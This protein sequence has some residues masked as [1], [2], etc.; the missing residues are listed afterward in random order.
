MVRRI[1]FLFLTMVTGFSIWGCSGDEIS[2]TTPTGN[3]VT[4][5]TN[6][7]VLRSDLNILPPDGSVTVDT[8]DDNQ[9]ILTGTVPTI[10]PGTALMM[11]SGPQQFIRRVVSVTTAD[12]K[13]VIQTTPGSL[14]DVFETANISQ[15]EVVGPE[16]LRQATPELDGVSFGEPVQSRTIEGG[17]TLPVNFSNSPLTDRFG[18]VMA[19]V[20]GQLNLTIGFQQ[21]L[22]FNASKFLDPPKTLERLRLVPFVNATG[23]LDID[24]KASG[25]FEQ[26]VKVASLGRIPLASLGPCTVTAGVD[27]LAYANGQFSVT[28]TTTLDGNAYAEFGLQATD[29]QFSLVNPSPEVSFTV[30]PP[31]ARGSADFSCGLARPSISIGVLGLGDVFVKADAFRAAVHGEFT[32]SPQPGYRIG[33][34]A[35]FSVLAGAVVRV[36]PYGFPPFQIPEYTIFNQTLQVVDFRLQLGD[37]V[38]IANEPV[39]PELLPIRLLL[40]GNEPRPGEGRF[41]GAL[42][43]L[44]TG[45]PIVP[46]VPIYFPVDW[47]S[48]NTNVLEVLAPNGGFTVVRAKRPGTAQLVGTYPDGKKL[49][50]DLTVPNAPIT[51]LRV[52]PPGASITTRASLQGR[53]IATYADGV[54]VDVTDFVDWATS[55]TGL[56]VVTPR[57]FF[58]PGQ[59]KVQARGGLLQSAAEGT[60]QLTANFQGLD[61]GVPITL[62]QPQVLQLDILNR[63][64]RI[65]PGDFRQLQ[66]V[67]F[68]ADGTSRLVSRQVEW[69]SDDV[70]VVNV[71]DTG[72]I[73]AGDS[74]QTRIRARLGGLERSFPISV[75]QPFIKSL[76]FDQDSV[77][78]AAGATQT[79]KIKAT[80]NDGDVQDVTQLAKIKILLPE[81]ANFDKGT[82]TGKQ[83]GASLVYATFGGRSAFLLVTVLPAQAKN[84]FVGNNGGTLNLSTVTV[85]GDGSLQV[86]NNTAAGGR[87]TDLLHFGDFVVASLSGP[88]FNRV[89]VF[90]FDA[91]AQDVNHVNP[92]F[93]FPTFSFQNL[94]MVKTSDNTFC[95][96]QPG[97][98]KVACFAIDLSTGALTQ[99]STI[100]TDS[101]SPEVLAASVIGA[102]HFLLI[103][104]VGE[105]SC[106]KI[107]SNNTLTQVAGS[108][109]ANPDPTGFAADVDVIN[110][111]VYVANLNSSTITRLGLNSTTGVLTGVVGSTPSGGLQPGALTHVTLPPAALVL[112]VANSGS[113]NVNAFAV[114]GSGALNP[115]AGFPISSQGNNPHQF[116]PVTLGNGDLALYL[117]TSNEVTGY[118][119]DV[120]SG[121][122]TP[123]TGSP[124][125]GFD[126]P[127]AITN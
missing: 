45:I 40:F 30:K 59:D 27:I 114:Q 126:S 89:Q 56:A 2:S 50:L 36:G 8:L 97:Q 88:T 17:W 90:K 37:P 77:S 103:G 117:S 76:A 120:V 23:H 28:G 92:P 22:R 42:S 85:N 84:L 78:L 112:Y 73:I 60:V 100:T 19:T 121:M 69:S 81:F 1:F 57:G 35:V 26:E 52:E 71:D 34:E 82:V 123:L 101:P 79:V 38:F 70:F 46:Y 64:D 66:A 7:F 104:D 29:G 51:N 48:S 11:N 72:E 21:E 87:V 127:E 115:V 16:A 111:N 43:L 6:D 24:A 75:G 3:T 12:G 99:S 91:Q 108:P 49:T 10:T 13:T 9:V 95:V 113:S 107:N 94:P 116:S 61:T 15:S 63:V 110:D 86:A 4:V 65:N 124:F 25:D 93:D 32:T 109:F 98:N 62:N 55:N 31:D 118:L 41:V 68:L 18:N 125:T 80:F 54:Q 14:L 44:G 47:S 53:A 122:L 20:N 67:A 39:K 102:N 74:G 83:T 58:H 33:T 119:I 5:N 106:Y 96:L 105:V